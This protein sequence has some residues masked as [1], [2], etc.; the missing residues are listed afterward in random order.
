MEQV[1][2]S[3]AESSTPELMTVPPQMF[4]DFRTAGIRRSDQ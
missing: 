4:C 3:R 2:N 1:Y